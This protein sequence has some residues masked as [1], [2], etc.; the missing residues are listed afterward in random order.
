MKNI[1]SL[2][3]ESIQI[4]FDGI[5]EETIL[6]LYA[7]PHILRLIKKYIFKYI[8]IFGCSTV[9]IIFRSQIIKMLLSIL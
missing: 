9:V 8:N 5:S 1:V 2:T 6:I 7:L 4:D 3:L